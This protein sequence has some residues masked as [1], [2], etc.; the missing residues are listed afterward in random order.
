L[1]E[2]RKL[3]DNIIT[4]GND[5]LEGLAYDDASV[6][7]LDNASRNRL[8]TV[9]VDYHAYPKDGRTEGICS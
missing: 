3:L 4:K 1:Q 9:T 8:R 7:R 6:Q 5:T 2:A